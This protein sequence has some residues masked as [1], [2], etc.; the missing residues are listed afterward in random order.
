MTDIDTWKEIQVL[1][2]GREK[3]REKK[4]ERKRQREGRQ[5]EGKKGSDREGRNSPQRG[6]Q[7]ATSKRHSWTDGRVQ[8]SWRQGRE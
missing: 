6:R 5:K 3:E 1:E 4:R 2:V 8:Q 7:D